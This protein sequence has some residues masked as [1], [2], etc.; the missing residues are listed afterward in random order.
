MGRKGRG[1]VNTGERTQLPCRAS[2]TFDVKTI[3][4]TRQ[5]KASATKRELPQERKVKPSC[6]YL[7]CSFPTFPSH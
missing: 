2:E 6:I 4:E 3:A 1:Q 7:S 5:G